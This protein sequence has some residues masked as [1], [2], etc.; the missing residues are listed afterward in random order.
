MLSE[1]SLLSAS[2]LLFRGEFKKVKNKELLKKFLSVLAQRT[3]KDNTNTSSITR[4]ALRSKKC[5]IGQHIYRDRFLL[6]LVFRIIPW[7]QKVLLNFV[8][9]KDCSEVFF[10]KFM[11]V[12]FILIYAAVLVTYVNLHYVNETKLCHLVLEPLKE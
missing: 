1:T 6:H 7:Q 10:F 3:N 9:S 12:D 5:M 11:I 8:L 2:L 4:F